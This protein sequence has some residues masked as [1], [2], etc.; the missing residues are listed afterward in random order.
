[1]FYNCG[2]KTINCT[3]NLPYAMLDR[4]FESCDFE[5]AVLKN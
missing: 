1:M 2:I 5:T 4:M 3:W